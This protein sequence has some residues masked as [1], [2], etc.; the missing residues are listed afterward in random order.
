MK[1]L[2][3]LLLTFITIA[4]PSFATVENISLDEAVD[5]ALKNNLELQARMKDLEIAKQEIKIANALKNP[6][7]QSNFLMG[8]VTRGNSSQFGLA[9][10][11]EIAKRGLRKKSAEAQMKA[12][13]NSLQEHR[14]NLKVDVMRAYFRIVYLKS[15]VKIMEQR[16]DLFEDMKNFAQTQ[17][18]NTQNYK[19]EVLQSDI[20][21]KRQLIELNKAKANLLAA[22]FNFNKVL[23]LAN[24]DV[25]Y[26]TQEASL[27]DDNVELL[28]VDIPSY[29]QI[30]KIALVCS[31]ALR[32]S[33]NYIEKSAYD[34]KTAEHKRIP[35][36]T[37]AGGY[38]YQ[39]KHQTGDVAL[40]GAFVGGNM[41]IPILYS[42]RPEINK[43][44][45][46][47]EK[48]KMDKVAYENKLK[49]I[50]KANYN[51]FKYAKENTGYYREI[52]SESE[53]I[54]K[55]SY[56]RYKSGKVPLMNVM[57]NENS[58]QQVL[59]EY[60]DSIDAYYQA[61]LDLMYNMGHDMLLKEDVL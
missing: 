16:E 39:T 12:I 5:I 44:K 8:R 23:N 21:Y 38:A 33:D 49:L 14:H 2:I 11:I 45:F 9:V 56:N 57:L 6:Q 29:D 19:I 18:K 7:F 41:D 36:V 40:P 53:E 60:I 17:S 52:L 55:M 10:P 54:L 30:E 35:D 31:Y 22:Q 34:V 4:L 15:V 43:A 61:Y 3:I 27:F 58:H 24:S 25:M 42:Y 26:D 37:I 1:R 48:T 46:I 32:I 13:E 28:N 51:D 59:N 47:L 50:L 20:K